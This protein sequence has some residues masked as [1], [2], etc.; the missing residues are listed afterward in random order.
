[1]TKDEKPDLDDEWFSSIK[2]ESQ[3]AALNNIHQEFK[4]MYKD[5]Y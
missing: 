2:E 1:M 5:E 3:E 4:G